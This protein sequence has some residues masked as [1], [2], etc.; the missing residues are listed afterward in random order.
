VVIAFMFFAQHHVCDAYF[1]PAINVFV[2]KMKKSPNAWLKRWGDE[3]VAGATICALGCNGPEMFTN[4][5]ALYTG[6]D[7]G[8]GVVVG[9]E[10]F[11]LLIIVGLT[12]AAAP[13]LPLSIERV[14]FA[15]DCFFYGVSIF[16]LYWAL[17]DKAIEWY[18]AYILLTAAGVYVLAVYFTEDLV[19]AIPALRPAG[20]N[21]K[22]V[23]KADAK[24]KGKMH[25]VEVEVEEIL[26]GRMADA[27]AA[28]PETWAIDPTSHGIYA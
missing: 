23:E 6:S 27:H 11:N 9:S 13:V 19:M 5:I 7:A 16:L 24:K 25:G 4:L 10:I 14:P 18:E 26:H 28:G 3:A 17:L 22:D 15:R 20:G 1:V 12:I 2:S 8:I 21:G